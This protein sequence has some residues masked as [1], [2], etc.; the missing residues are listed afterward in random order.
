M[1]HATT[2]AKTKGAKVRARSKTIR[3]AVVNASA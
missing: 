1:K 3:T 2:I